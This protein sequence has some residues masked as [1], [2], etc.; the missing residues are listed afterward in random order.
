MFGAGKPKDSNI[1]DLF[2]QL[3]AIDNKSIESVRSEVIDSIDVESIYKSESSTSVK[4]AALK[5]AMVIETHT[6]ITNSINSS[7]LSPDEVIAKQKAADKSLKDAQDA[8]NKDLDQKEQEESDDLAEESIH[9][10]E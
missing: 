10:E 2:E 7:S 6:R 8:A 1:R 5:K 9:S 4:D 3:S